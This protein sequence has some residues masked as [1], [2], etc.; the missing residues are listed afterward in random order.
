MSDHVHFL[1]SEFAAQVRIGRR[2]AL[3]MI[4]NGTLRAVDVSLKPGG[5]PTWRIPAEEVESF[6][7]RRTKQP[8]APR[9]RRRKSAPLVKEYF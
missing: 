3:A 6:L 8:A 5:R 1:V 9:R 7:R 4:R 2:A